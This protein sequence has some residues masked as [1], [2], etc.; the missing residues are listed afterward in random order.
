MLVMSCDICEYM[1]SAYPVNEW[2]TIIILSGVLMNM[3]L[4][5]LEFV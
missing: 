3:L 2:M 4:Q 1:P 5:F